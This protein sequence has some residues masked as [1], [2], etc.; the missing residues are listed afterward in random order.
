MFAFTS[1]CSRRRQLLSCKLLYTEGFAGCV[2]HIVPHVPPI[3]NIVGGLGANSA[4]FHMD[5]SF[6]NCTY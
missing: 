1:S 6:I 2:D 3:S 4:K 5:I